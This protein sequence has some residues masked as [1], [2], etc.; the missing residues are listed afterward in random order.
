MEG[1]EQMRADERQAAIVSAVNERGSISI[2][3]FAEEIGV[4]AVTLRVDVR[5][6][7]RRGLIRRVHGGAT[8]ASAPDHG[9]AP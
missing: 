5:E 8:R 1:T 6:L 2:R 3:E 4:A 7:A 9:A